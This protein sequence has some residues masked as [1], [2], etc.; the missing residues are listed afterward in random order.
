MTV[1]ATFFL[2]R[3]AATDSDAQGRITPLP[4]SPLT[5]QGLGQAESAAR[6]IAGKGVTA[7]ICGPGA[8]ERQ[9]AELIGNLLDIRVSVCDD[10][11]EM[12]FGLWQGRTGEELDRAQPA[13][14]RQ[15]LRGPH[16][17]RPP[18]GETVAEAADRLTP[19]VL[20]ITRGRPGLLVVIDKIACA[21]V[22]CRMTGRP[23]SELWDNVGRAC[24]FVR[25]G[26]HKPVQTPSS[27]PLK[28][29]IHNG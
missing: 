20:K 4:G 26:G 18:G 13:I 7:I 23:L 17:V 27:E 6:A 10:L 15:W 11:M 25:L 5:R 2:M 3:S 29:E 24:D 1:M 21:A 8:G 22:R 14:Y 9:T 16:E 19:V 28:A 12:D